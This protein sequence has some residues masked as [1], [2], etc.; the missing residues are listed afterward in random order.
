MSD[1][2]WGDDVYQPQQPEASDPA[3]QLGA[4]DTLMDPSGTGDPLD[5]GY[6]PPDRPWVVE[7]LGTTAN[8]RHTGESLER[9][10]TRRFPSRTALS[11]TVWAIWWTA[12]ASP[13][14]TRWASPAPGG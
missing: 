7:G 5:E 6:A 10:L 8:E 13:G 11:A 4:E 1:S 14:T 3:E 12:T 9:R 2:D